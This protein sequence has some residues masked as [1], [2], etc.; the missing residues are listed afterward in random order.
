MCSVGFKN[1]K[2]VVWQQGRKPEQNLSALHLYPQQIGYE[3]A[4]IVESTH[5]HQH[6]EIQCHPTK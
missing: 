3:A 1:P 2:K 5:H 6:L 4:C